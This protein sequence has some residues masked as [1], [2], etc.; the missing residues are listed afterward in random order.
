[1]NE[2]LLNNDE[3]KE[4][5]ESPTIRKFRIVR[6]DAKRHAR[7]PIPRK[8]VSLFIGLEAG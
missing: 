3:E 1:M 7:S 5:A 8:P 6:I 2:H 4:L